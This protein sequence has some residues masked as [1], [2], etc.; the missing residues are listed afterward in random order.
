MRVPH[1]ATGLNLFWP[2]RKRETLRDSRT[3]RAKYFSCKQ[4]SRLVYWNIR[5]RP[6]RAFPACSHRL[7]SNDLWSS[8]R[9][10]KLYISYISFRLL[11]YIFNTRDFSAN[12]EILVSSCLEL[13][14][15]IVFIFCVLYFQLG[16]FR[17]AFFLTYF[18]RH[19]NLKPTILWKFDCE[20]CSVETRRTL[21]YLIW[22]EIAK[23]LLRKTALFAQTAVVRAANSTQKFLMKMYAR[24][25]FLFF[26]NE[27]LFKFI[28]FQI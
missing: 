10:R 20:M 12:C 21:F 13:L 8:Q 7:L 3:N 6:C 19:K 22:I 17:F 18:L 9:N 15:F 2:C 27:L 1:Y 26:A 28:Q 16:L 23:W 5:R 25:F 14:Y 11:C 4:P 24:V